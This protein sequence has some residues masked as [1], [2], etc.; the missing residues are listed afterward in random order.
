MSE[1]IYGLLGAL[2]GALITSAAAYWGP[3]QIQ[4]RV[5]TAEAERSDAARRE[6]E[7][8]REAAQ[9][10]AEQ[11]R[12]TS[13]AL[14]E[15][16]RLE[17]AAVQ[18]HTRR[19]SEINRIISVRTTTRGWA[20]LLARTVQD[21]ELGRHVDIEQFDTEISTAR[22]KAHA[23]LDHALHGGVWIP[24]STYGYPS[25]G[26]AYPAPSQPGRPDEQ[27]RGL[28]VALGKVTE[29]IRAAVIRGERSDDSQSAALRQALDRADLAR[30]ALATALLNRLEDLMSIT[31]IGSPLP[32]DMFRADTSSPFGPPLS[33]SP[34][35]PGRAVTWPDHPA[36][37]QAPRVSFDPRDDGSAR[38]LEG[39]G[40]FNL[41]Y[42]RMALEWDPADALRSADQAVRCYEA[43]QEMTGESGQLSE[44]REVQALA[45][46]KI[47][48]REEDGGPEPSMD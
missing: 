45:R 42:A 38:T 4:R 15:S 36:L 17:A 19:E 46:E 7:A 31:V 35:E 44:A 8:E 26:Y 21:I 23:A 39:D 25:H 32:A 34:T 13:A 24:Q 29:L 33:W 43:L 1:A 3:L 9:Q 48:Q 28:V 10:S 37:T 47:R 12:I 22:G 30:G 41:S 20:D 6:A 14:R 16:E 18:A 2:G 40:S 27:L 11:E 5:H